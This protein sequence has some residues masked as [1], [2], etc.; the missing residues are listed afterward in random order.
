MNA[1]FRTRLQDYNLKFNRRVVNRSGTFSVEVMVEMLFFYGVGD[2]FFQEKIYI[3]SS[4]LPPQI[5]FMA[6]DRIMQNQFEIQLKAFQS[7]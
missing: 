6:G 5:W 3:E 7:F 2:D 4:F 1:D